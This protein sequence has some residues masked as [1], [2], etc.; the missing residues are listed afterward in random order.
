M[1]QVKGRS[2][3]PVNSCPS[4]VAMPTPT[5]P[6]LLGEWAEG[7]SA[8]TR[9]II[10]RRS[11]PDPFVFAIDLSVAWSRSSLPE[12]ASILKDLDSLG[13]LIL[14]RLDVA[15]SP[16][17]MV[18]HCPDCAKQHIDAP[19]PEAGWTNP[20]HKSHTCHGCGTVWRPADVETVGVA[21]IETRG[22]R[23]TWNGKANASWRRDG[24]ERARE[25]AQ[26][27]LDYMAQFEGGIC[28]GIIEKA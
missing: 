2:T 14:R 25:E 26:K 6:G 16:L 28:K 12:S 23:D 24:A 22:S 18:L 20:P 13:E 11:R 15:S 19:E 17:P 1:G 21:A 8:E 3:S 5:F 10:G 27:H 9:A 4:E 7:C